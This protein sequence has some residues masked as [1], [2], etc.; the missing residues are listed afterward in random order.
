MV[1]A[2]I[3]PNIQDLLIPLVV[4]LHMENDIAVMNPHCFGIKF[5]RR[6]IGGRSFFAILQ[7]RKKVLNPEVG[8]AQSGG[9]VHDL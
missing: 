2:T 3:E 5:N 1:S 8:V 6:D 7:D 4:W 9:R